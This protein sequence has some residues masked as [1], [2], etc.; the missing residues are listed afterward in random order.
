MERNRRENQQQLCNL[1]LE[2]HAINRVLKYL[3]IR[4][5]SNTREFVQPKHAR[6]ESKSNQ[7]SYKPG[8]V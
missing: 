8:S 2:L 4:V 7:G 5:Y 6:P 1:I 3:I